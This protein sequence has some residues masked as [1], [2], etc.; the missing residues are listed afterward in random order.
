VLFAVVGAFYYLRVVKLVYF[1][2]ATD[3]SAFRAGG[4][5]RVVLS[6]NAL[7]VLLI[8]PWVGALLQICRDAVSTLSG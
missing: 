7:A 4:D 5:M 3:Q 8:M 6:I 1:D 2:D